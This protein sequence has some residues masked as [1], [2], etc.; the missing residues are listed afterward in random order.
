MITEIVYIA[1]DPIRGADFE[2]AV[3]SAQSAFRAAEGCHSVTLERVIEEPGQYRL[4]VE[5]DS[6]DHHMVKFR[7]S[8]GFKEW[9]AHAGP[10]FLGTPRVEHSETAV[11]L[12]F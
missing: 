3:A 5:W 12:T 6:V 7:Q 8:D 2:A 1:V 11:R 10:F 4:L 9:R